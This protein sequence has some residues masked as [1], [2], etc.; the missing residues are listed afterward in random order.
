MLYEQRPGIHIAGGGLRIDKPEFAAL[1]IVE[2]LN[3]RISPGNDIAL[4]GCSLIDNR[5]DNGNNIA[6][7]F[8]RYIGK[9]GEPAN[10]HHA[11]QQGPA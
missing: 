3:L 7:V 10:V 9:R 1:Q 11:V 8:R 5:S 4:V 2:V 6:L